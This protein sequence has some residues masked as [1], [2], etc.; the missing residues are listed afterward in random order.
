MREKFSF[1]SKIFLSISALTIFQ[2]SSSSSLRLSDNYDSPESHSISSSSNVFSPSDQLIL[3]DDDLL[4]NYN[5]DSTN[6]HIYAVTS[7]Y[8]YS[9]EGQDVCLYFTNFP[10]LKI[11]QHFKIAASLTNHVRP[12]SSWNNQITSNQ[13][14]EPSKV[15]FVK[16][17]KQKLGQ[18]KCFKIKVPE[19]ESDQVFK[20]TFT[21]KYG[22]NTEVNAQNLIKIRPSFPVVFITTDKPIYKAGQTVRYKVLVLDR[23]MKPF[24]RSL[25][26]HL[27]E[28]SVK[29]PQNTKLDSKSSGIWLDQY[30]MYSG[31]FNLIEDPSV[32]EWTLGVQLQAVK[33]AVA[34]VTTYK[35]KF[36]V[37]KYNLPKFNMQITGLVRYNFP[38]IINLFRAETYK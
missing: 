32:G 2:P 33:S 25:K 21:V 5:H 20:L 10:E 11:N 27:V 31:D 17:V 19:V 12:V 22:L 1:S 3:L 24:R 34:K 29:N 4:P 15:I 16:K 23:H 9:G 18:K 30:G 35:T 38:K 36:S 6:P 14:M 26:P 8:F 37:Q 28:V 13:R 7:K